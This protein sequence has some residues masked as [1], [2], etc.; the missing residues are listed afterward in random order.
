M[1]EYFVV[2][3]VVFLIDVPRMKIAPSRDPL[4]IR[5]VVHCCRVLLQHFFRQAGNVGAESDMDYGDQAELKNT[6]NNHEFELDWPRVHTFFQPDTNLKRLQRGASSSVGLRS[7]S[8]RLSFH[9][10]PLQGDP[11]R[12]IHNV[13]NQAMDEQCLSERLRTELEAYGFEAL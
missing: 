11:L 2:H 10:F 13:N 12:K 8:T 3:S 7:P 9:L 1:G 5:P 6:K 4:P